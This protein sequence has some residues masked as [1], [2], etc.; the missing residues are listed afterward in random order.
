MDRERK[1]YA[2]VRFSARQDVADLFNDVRDGIVTNINVGYQIRERTLVK[3]KT[4]EGQTSTE[5]RH[6]S[7]MEISLVSGSSG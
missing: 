6:G 1:G 5:L 3:R 4:T 7:P 2:D